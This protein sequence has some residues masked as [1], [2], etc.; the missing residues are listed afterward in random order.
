MAEF[1]RET[2]VPADFRPLVPGGTFYHCPGNGLWLFWKW[3]EALNLGYGR[4]R[5]EREQRAIPF[6]SGVRFALEVAGCAFVP[7]IEFAIA[8]GVFADV[9]D[10]RSVEYNPDPEFAECLKE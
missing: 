4:I 7:P 10:R 2:A 8:G 6:I 9:A 5:V 1:A 3:P